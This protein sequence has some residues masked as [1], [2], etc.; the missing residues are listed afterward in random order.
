[1]E[2]DCSKLFLCYDEQTEPGVNIGSTLSCPNNTLMHVNFNRPI[3]YTCEGPSSGYT[4]PGSYHFGCQGGDF[5]ELT[6][7]TAMP[8]TTTPLA[9][10]NY[11]TENTFGECRCEGQIMISNDCSSGFFCSSGS[12]PQSAVGYL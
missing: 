1:M 9:T 4:C 11:P 6:T 12:D 2:D 8:D 7:S 5:G 3:T 10:C